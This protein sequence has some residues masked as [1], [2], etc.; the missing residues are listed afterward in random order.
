MKLSHRFLP[1]LGLAF[2]VFSCEPKDEVE[3]K[4]AE[5]EELKAESNKL[6][7]S[8]AELEEELMKLDPDFAKQ[9]QKSILITTIPAKKGEFDHYVE[10]TGSVLSK[11]NVMISAETSGRILEVP[12]LEGMR[13]NKGT[14]LARIDA[15]I[16]ER[17]IDE[18][19][20]SLELATTLFEKQE[21]LWNQQIGTEVQYLEAKNRKEGL[22][23]NLAS[24]RTNLDKA[25]IRA[26]FSGTIETVEVRLGELVQPGMGMFQFIGESDLFIEADIS[27]SYIGVLSKGDSVDVNFP[28][29]N[30]D[31][32]T[33]VSSVGAIINPNNRT[34]KVEVLLPNMSMV[35]PN[36]I[37][38]LKILDYQS[39]DAVIVPSYL[40]LSDNRGDYVFTVESGKAVKKY[41]ERGKTFDKETEILEGLTGTE[42]LVDKGF[43]E[44][45]DNFNVN[46]A[47]Q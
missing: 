11:K 42:M 38:V 3:E 1:L 28:S 27:E 17:N 19:E 45:G 29:I 13:V 30:K 6:T 46:I 9:N 14:V 41:V 24:A 21:R 12:V 8:I 36:M 23:R 31:I 26:P 4:K 37:S 35:K 44:V 25:I 32:Q 40:I 20:N 15:E 39:A 7:T 22:E 16:I 5:L 47:Q 34:F 18:L 43:R 10:V 33:K 2:L